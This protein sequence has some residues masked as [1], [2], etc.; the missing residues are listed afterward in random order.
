MNMKRKKKT[1]RIEQLR[2]DPDFRA[3]VGLLKRQSPDRVDAFR[4]ECESREEHASC[5]ECA[6]DNDKGEEP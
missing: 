2:Q 5:D 3:L 4:D 6:A 1:D